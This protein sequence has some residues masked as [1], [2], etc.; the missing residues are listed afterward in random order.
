MIFGSLTVLGAMKLLLVAT[1]AI[2]VAGALVS[3]R[4]RPEPGAVPL[5]L[6]LAGQCWWSATLFF[7]IDAAGLGAKVFWIDV[8]WLGIVII[9]VAWLL[10]SLEYTGYSEYVRP[11][12]I[13]LLSIVPAVTAIIGLTNSYHNLMY[14]DS[15]LTTEA[16]SAVLVRTPA[17]WF[18]V[19]ALYTYLLGLL[20][21]I[22]LLQFVT[23][24]I[25]TFRGQ[26]LAILLG[27]FVPW[28]TNILFI[29]DVLPTASIDPTP[30]AFMISGMAYLGALT[31]FQMFGTSPAPINPARRSVFDRMQEGAIVLDRQDHI[32]DMNAKAVAALEMRPTDALGRPVTDVVP[33]FDTLVGDQESRQTVFRPTDSPRAYDIS[34]SP[35][36]DAHGRTTGRILTLH[37]ITD[38][39]RQQQRLEVLN[40]VFRHNIRTNTQVIVSNAEY[41]ADHNSEEKAAKVRQ[42]ALDIEDLSDKIRTVL[43]V[44]EQGREQTEPVKI[45]SCLRSQLA[46]IRESHPDVTVDCRL[47]S[48]ELHVDGLMKEVFWQILENAATHNTNAEPELTVEV[49]SNDDR[50][51]ITVADNGPGIDDKELALVQ[52]GT[53]TPLEHGSGFGL[54]VIV[55]GTEIAGGRVSFSKNDPSGTV[56]TVDVPVLLSSEQKTE[57]SRAAGTGSVMPP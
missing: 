26:S 54:A 56:V 5:T 39:L 49:E 15:A 3:W 33:E 32:V 31:Q 41:L 36:S 47:S 24:D 40:R 30:I 50:V 21:A 8:S 12:Y 18:W 28:V 45:N 6:L 48:R 37:D 42:K 57:G 51:E 46:A 25:N 1:I 22:P 13:A 14:L 19:A 23:S 55:W 38:Y 11:R 34:V 35:L 17:V 20:G 4:E 44:F 2:G 29:L 52:K 27:L 43:E 53:E 9:P 10:F 7:R 16:G